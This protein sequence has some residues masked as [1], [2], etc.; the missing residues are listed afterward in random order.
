VRVDIAMKILENCVLDCFEDAARNPK[1]SDSV[2]D[3]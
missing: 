3:E 1:N 2:L